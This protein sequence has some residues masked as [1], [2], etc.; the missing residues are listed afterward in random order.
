MHLRMTKA[1]ELLV[2]QDMSIKEIC[3]AVGFN[4]ENS[5]YKAFKRTYGI[6]PTQYRSAKKL[7]VVDN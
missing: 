5:F 7:P 2:E 3:Y 1:A 6:T 4:S